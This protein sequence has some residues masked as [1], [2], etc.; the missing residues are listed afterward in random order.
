MRTEDLSDLAIATRFLL[1]FNI[2]EAITNFTQFWMKS[3]VN[4]DKHKNK[5]V[6]AVEHVSKLAQQLVHLCSFQGKQKKRKQ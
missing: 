2:F 1:N 4:Y 3:T 5:F 6:R